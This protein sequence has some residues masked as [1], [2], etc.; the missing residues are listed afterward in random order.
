MVEYFKPLMAWLEEQNIGARSGWDQDDKERQEDREKE[1]R[2][3]RGQEPRGRGKRAGSPIQ[4]RTGRCR[5]Y[6][7]RDA[8]LAPNDEP[9]ADVE[10]TK[11]RILKFASDGSMS[12]GSRRRAG[13]P[14]SMSC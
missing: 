2:A 11:E 6:R 3:E 10:E 9:D 7:M 13:G 5:H 8:A 14:W 12:N 4:T 1:E